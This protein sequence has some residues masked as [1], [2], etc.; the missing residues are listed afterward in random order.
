MGKGLSVNTLRAKTKRSAK[1]KFQGRNFQKHKG[2]QNRTIEHP[3]G[4]VGGTDSYP[5][6]RHPVIVLE[7]RA[8]RSGASRGLQ[9]LSVRPRGK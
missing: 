5:S 7:K 6:I 8:G 3:S 9:L 1:T 4:G 2:L